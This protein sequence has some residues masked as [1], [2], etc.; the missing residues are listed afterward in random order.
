MLKQYITQPTLVI[1]GA[2][3]PDI[4]SPSWVANEAM[5]LG[6][7]PDF[8]V[9]VQLPIGNPTLR[10]TYEFDKIKFNAARS[11]LTFYLASDDLDQVAKSVDTA[12][13]ILELLSHTPV[14]GFGFNFSHEIEC[15]HLE[16]RKTFSGSDISAL[17]ADEDAQTVVQRWGSSI[18]TQ[19]F[20]LSLNAEFEGGNK[21][22]LAF[23]VH[24]E[25][26]SATEA[27]QLLRTDGVFTTAVQITSDIAQKLHDLD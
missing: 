26:A 2:W 4:L 23:N 3:N 5:K 21:V 18:K 22:T 19:Q 11:Q 1:A 9:N 12:A 14:T 8:A 27:A 15:P 20:L 6:L 25:V 17:L 10:P 7:T 13:R 16:L 24:Y